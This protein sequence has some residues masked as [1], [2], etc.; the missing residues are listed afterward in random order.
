VS[1]PTS[2]STGADLRHQ[3]L[4]LAS[5]IVED[6][7]YRSETFYPTSHPE[8]QIYGS[9]VQKRFEPQN[10]SGW[11]ASAAKVFV[12]TENSKIFAKLKGSSEV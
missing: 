5:A 9:F 1:L 3:S 2:Y 12:Y 10:A 8:S 4:T 11:D 7:E 6:I